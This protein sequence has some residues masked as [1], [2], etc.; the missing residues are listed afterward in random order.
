MCERDT[1]NQRA[2]DNE[3]KGKKQAKSIHLFEMN[4]K[5]LSLN[6]AVCQRGGREG[7]LS[8]NADRCRLLTSGG[9]PVL[10]YAPVPTSKC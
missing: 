2:A 1:Q 3:L 7:A 10:F 8:S 6:T 9:A 5:I 4:K